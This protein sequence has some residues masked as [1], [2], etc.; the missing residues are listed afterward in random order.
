MPKNKYTQF[1]KI[2]G[3][4]EFNVYNRIYKI[5]VGKIT[6][7]RVGTWMHWCL[8]LDLKFMEIMVKKKQKWFLSNGCL[9]E[10]SKFITSLYSKKINN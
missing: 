3:K 10:I 9:K 4:R 6:R 7:E 2:K 5:K 8:T 1:K